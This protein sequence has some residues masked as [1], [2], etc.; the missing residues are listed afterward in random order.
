MKIVT[1][2]AAAAALVFSSLSLAA[3]VNVNSANAEQIAEAL[4][5]IGMARAQAIVAYRDSNGMFTSADDLVAVKGIGQ[6]TLER[7]RDDILVK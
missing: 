1:P 5:G 2:L 6:A 3:P 4:N 7:N